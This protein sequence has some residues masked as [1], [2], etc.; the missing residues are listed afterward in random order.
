MGRPRVDRSNLPR[1]WVK[2]EHGTWWYYDK[3]QRTM[4][5]E[6]T[7]GICGKTFPFKVA[8]AK[9]QPG[10]YCSRTCANRADKPGRSE[11][12]GGK[13]RYINSYGYVQVLVA[14]RKFRAEHRI[15]M[16]EKLGRSLL[17]EETV[18]HIN[19]KRD[20]NRPENLELWSSRHPKGQRVED[21]VSFAREILELY[22]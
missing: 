13:G 19:G 2:D 9:H 18:H 15:V 14:P 22:G 6:R 20:D 12:R 11:A 10:L 1:G 16:E 8:M 21:L 17:P 5:E 4:G 3:R 7:C